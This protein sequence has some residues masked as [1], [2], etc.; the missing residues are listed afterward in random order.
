MGIK[1][2]DFGSL[3]QLPKPTSQPQDKNRTKIWQGFA[4]TIVPKKCCLNENEPIEEN[5]TSRDIRYGY[6]FIVLDHFI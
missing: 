3:G 2:L 6:R 4:Y 5:S 1:V